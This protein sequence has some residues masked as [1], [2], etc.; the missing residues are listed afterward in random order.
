MAASVLGEQSP[1]VLAVGDPL[2]PLVGQSVAGKPL[3]LPSAAAGKSVVVIFSF[4]RAGGRDAQN[5]AQHLSKDDPQLPIFTAIFL[6][7]VPRIFRPMAVSGIQSGMPAAM[8]ERTLLLYQQQTWWE[9]M[10]H[11][12]NDAYACVLLLDKS[13]HVRWMSPGPFADS[14]YVRLIEELRLE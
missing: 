11:V 6:E 10:L 2:P 1:S 3:G 5:W 8:L 13:G 9:R 14:T 4:S 7:S 12:A